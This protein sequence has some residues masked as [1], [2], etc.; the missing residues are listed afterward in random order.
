METE[1]GEIKICFFP[2]GIQKPHTRKLFSQVRM[3]IL[4]RLKGNSLF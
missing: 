1:T 2:S 4:Y 3:L